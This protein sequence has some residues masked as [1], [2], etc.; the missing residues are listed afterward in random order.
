M[1]DG[2]CKAAACLPAVLPSTLF[3]T[4][5]RIPSVRLVMGLGF[6]DAMDASMDA[7]WMQLGLDLYLKAALQGTNPNNAA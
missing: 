4:Q 3:L 5:N 7:I 6:W 1:T 2:G